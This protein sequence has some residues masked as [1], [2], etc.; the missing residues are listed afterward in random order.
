[1]F[2]NAVRAQVTVCLVTKVPL[3]YGFDPLVHSCTAGLV[4]FKSLC[5]LGMNASAYKDTKISRLCLIRVN[6][7]MTSWKKAYFVLNLAKVTCSTQYQPCRSLQENWFILPICAY[8]HACLQLWLNF[9]TYLCLLLQWARFLIPPKLLWREI[10]I[11]LSMKRRILGVHVWYM[12]C[13]PCMHARVHVHIVVC[14]VCL[15]C[16]SVCTCACACTYWTWRDVHAFS[17]IPYSHVCKL[18][19]S[20]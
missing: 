12:S 1:M 3:C 8:I 6:L 4:F 13:M 20:I 17:R 18:W 15:A 9:S 10:T 5:R 7:S 16:T 11:W 2:E 19:L 14:C